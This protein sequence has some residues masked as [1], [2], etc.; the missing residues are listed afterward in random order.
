MSRPLPKVPLSSRNP[1]PRKKG[2]LAAQVFVWAIAAAI[3]AAGAIQVTQQVFYGPA[4]GSPHATCHEG[5]RALLTAVDQARS[6]AAGTDGEDAALSRFRSALEPAWRHR[7]AIAAQCKGSARDEG[8]LD[9]IERLRYAEEHA[10]RREAG[11]LAP[12]RRR[13]QV[14]VDRDL[15]SSPP[16]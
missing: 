3:I 7:D 10:V 12:L 11:S 13:V 5:L 9:A 16:P 6:A 14:I 15:S 2:R 1:S 8:A 4:E